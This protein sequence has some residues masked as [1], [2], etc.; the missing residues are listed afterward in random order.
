MDLRN[1]S[2]PSS[3]NTRRVPNTFLKALMNR[4]LSQACLSFQVRE[5]LTGCCT[6]PSHCIEVTTL[7]RLMP[8]LCGEYV[9]VSSLFN[10]FKH[11]RPSQPMRHFI[12]QDEEKRISQTWKV[13]ISILSLIFLGMPS[14]FTYNGADTL[15]IES[16]E[17]GR[18]SLGVYVM[19][20]FGAL[21]YS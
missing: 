18:N 5:R 20:L 14:W 19:L 10:L 2:S 15:T 12:L 8:D 17:I 1:W 21:H 7:S 6:K 11:F 13:G 9:I 16:V 3:R 4:E